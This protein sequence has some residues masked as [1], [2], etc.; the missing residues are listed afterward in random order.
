[1]IVADQGHN[2]ILDDNN[3][4]TKTCSL[5]FF[6]DA[7]INGEGYSG[8]TNQEVLRALIDRVKFLDNQ[9]PSEFNLK[10]LH[11]LRMA[12]ILHEQRHLDRLVERKDEIEGIEVQ[13]NGHFVTVGENEACQN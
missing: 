1:M 5:I 6:K 7:K 12:L 9:V 2:Y 4:S 11:H 13:L 10:I 3:R 8:T